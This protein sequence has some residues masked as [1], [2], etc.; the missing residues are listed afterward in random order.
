MKIGIYRR[1]VALAVCV[2]LLFTPEAYALRLE[3][4]AD[5][6]EARAG[7]EEEVR[8]IR[9][10]RWPASFPETG[11][12]EPTPLK[13]AGME[14]KIP[15]S[16]RRLRQLE[17]GILDQVDQ[18]TYSNA[19]T[20]KE[21]IWEYQKFVRS[22]LDPD[23][24][25]VEEKHDSLLFFN[26]RGLKGFISH[27]RHAF[28]A[29]RKLNLKEFFR[30]ALAGLVKLVSLVLQVQGPSVVPIAPGGQKLEGFQY[31][32]GV[33]VYWTAI[34]F[35]VV[36]AV[37]KR[38]L[39]LPVLLNAGIG[40][41]LFFVGAHV[42]GWIVG[43]V[44]GHEWTHFIQNW[45]IEKVRLQLRLPIDFVSFSERLTPVF[46]R[47]VSFRFNLGN[48]PPTKGQLK[49]VIQDLF[50]E[51]RSVSTDNGQFP[52][53]VQSQGQP[54]LN[55]YLHLE[56]VL[57]EFVLPHLIEQNEATRT[58]TFS[59]LRSGTGEDVA[60]FWYWLRKWFHAQGL[61]L[62]GKEGWTVRFLLV[63]SE[64]DVS[65]EA[66][67]RFSGE[68]PFGYAFVP[69]PVLERF[70]LPI[71]NT[72]SKDAGYLSG[73]VQTFRSDL[74]KEEEIRLI[75][76]QSDFI[77]AGPD[78]LG[79]SEND[80]RK[81]WRT[82][83]EQARPWLLIG[84]PLFEEEVYSEG[85]RSSPIIFD[86]GQAQALDWESQPDYS[87]YLSIS[88]SAGEESA[89]GAEELPAPEIDKRRLWNQDP[90]F[91]SAADYFNEQ[92]LPAERFTWNHA[93]ELFRRFRGE[94][95]DPKI[96]AERIS[97]L[98]TEGERR[99]PGLFDRIN[100]GTFRDRTPAEVAEHAAAIYVDLA[101]QPQGKSQW[102]VGLYGFH[103]A[104]PEKRGDSSDPASG[105][106]RLG[107]FMMN[108]FL[109][110]N[111]YE[112]FY[113]LNS[114][115]VTPTPSRSNVL[116]MVLRRLKKQSSPASAGLEEGQTALLEAPPASQVR[117]ELERLHRSP[118]RLREFSR[119]F[120]E[121]AETQQRPVAILFAPELI[122]GDNS[123]A[124]TME[125]VE[126]EG[127]FPSTVTFELALPGKAGQLLARG[128]QVIRLVPESSSEGQ[129]SRQG[130]LLA[131]ADA[132]VAASQT[133]ARVGEPFVFLVDLQLYQGFNEL[134]YPTFVVTFQELL[135]A[136]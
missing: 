92:I 125:L 132:Y 106:H 45:A 47:T 103:Y 37:L 69:G 71:V 98:E 44:V 18:S 88:P 8:G 24:L 21:R 25:R 113:F 91:L 128:V 67:R 135:E 20:K 10:L 65:N 26:L 121:I 4:I 134:D 15:M 35:W 62:G 80:E 124:K 89:A 126:A 27:L 11:S 1:G 50:L 112:P 66:R 57:T 33:K 59:F 43:K 28:Y 32:S 49:E 3:Q 34:L 108:V 74:T 75:A 9:H 83:G 95:E 31:A 29:L 81:L 36:S 54:V 131:A 116:G 97:S 111:G 102:L 84:R 94:P 105:H 30:S 12:F 41:L 52:F 14:E 120:R 73:A 6:V 38:G 17:E 60:R 109:V 39:V 53:P 72:V 19:S 129:L 42:F 16:F 40:F 130:I 136:A 23:G 110:R 78:S 104:A 46:E 5:N 13:A 107:W 58:L 22:L 86:F 63:D 93:V 118:E 55:R 51:I 68:E 127:H 100:D 77:F 76:G 56:E 114:W 2:A 64:E 70:A 82:L 133:P 101:G 122:S 90:D 7:M 87:F 85:S 123:L 99:R 61:P 48:E 79:L 115:E 96:Q 119:G 117:R